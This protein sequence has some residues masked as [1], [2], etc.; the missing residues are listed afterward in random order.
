MRLVP[1]INRC[2]FAAVTRARAICWLFI[3]LISTAIRCEAVPNVVINE[4][5]YTEDNPT[6]HSEFIELYNAGT[7]SVDLSGCYFD[8]GINYTL[9]AGTILAAGAYL[10]VCEDPATLQT[11]WGVA[12]AGVLSWQTAAPATYGLLSNGGEPIVLRDPAG[13]KIDEVDYGQGFPWPTVGEPPNY[14][15]ELINPALDNSLGGHWRSSKTLT[16]SGPTPRARNASYADNAPPATRRVGHA[17]ATPVNIQTWMKSGQDVRITAKVTDPDGVQSVSLQYQIVE[18]GDYIKDDDSRY[19]APASWTTIAMQDDGRNG[20]LLAADAEYGCV[21]PGSVQT[22]RRLI[23]YRIMVTDALGASIRVPYADDPQPNFAYF[24]YDGVPDWSGSPRPGVAPVVTYASSVLESVPQY[25]LITRIA[26][27]SNAQNV[28]VIKEDGT[29]NNP[30]A[31]A[32]GHSLY[33]WKGALCYDGVVYDHI[34][35]R[36]RGG[37][38]RFAMGKNMWKFDFNK[39]HDFAPRDNY[40][41]PY[42]EK[43]K[44]LNFSAVIQQGDYNHRGEQ[45]LFESVG[46]RLFQLTG[47]PAEHTQFVHFRIIERANETNNTANQF[48]DDFQGL[49]LGIEQQD[50]QFLDEHGLPDG[51]L[52]KME[53]GGGELNNQGPTQPSNKSDLN[54]FLAYQTN[55]QWWRTNCDLTNYYN[56]RAIVDCI[57]HYD[58]GDGKNYFFYHNPVTNKWSV[59]PW[60]LDLTWSDNM[61]RADNGIEGL[62]PSG[63]STEPFFSRVFGNGTTTGIPALRMEHRNRMREVL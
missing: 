8:S 24:V 58:I 30:T 7:A 20:D 12:G 55:E 47:L 18:P 38:W 44:K 52:Y 26:E 5:H 31:G 61:Y 57:H 62:P 50:G 2:H 25:H 22:H 16:A 11:K 40:G 43:W 6:V 33:L 41:K 56:Y 36:A 29:N 54:A 13:A 63:N 9:P 39:G 14:S 51:N 35:F 4:I 37:V 32:Y 34:R 42:G 19:N 46:F 60:D 45:G 17:P 1:P 3:A 27:H 28:P 48:D 10:V 21:I 15:I 23:R 53:G 49:Y 59:L